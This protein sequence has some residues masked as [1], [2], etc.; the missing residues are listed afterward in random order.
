MIWFV[1]AKRDMNQDKGRLVP[2]ASRMPGP[3][4]SFFSF[5]FFYR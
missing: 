3:L 2:I 1:E 5:F 4:H